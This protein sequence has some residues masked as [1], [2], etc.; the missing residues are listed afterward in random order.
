MNQNHLETLTH[1]AMLV[2]WGQFAQSM[3]LIDKIE[4]IPLH[5]KTVTHSPQ[6]KVLEFLV[7]ILAG[8]EHLQDLSR[9]AHPIDQDQ[10]VA[11]AWQ[12]AGWADYSG[13]SRTLSGLT[14]AEAEQIVGV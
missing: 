4:S 13:V 3:G 12:Q 2:V 14:Q 6:G 9:S 8:L 10:A 5:Q 11:K 1:H 7:A